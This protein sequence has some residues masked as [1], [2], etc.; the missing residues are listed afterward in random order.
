MESQ[1]S[2]LDSIMEVSVEFDRSAEKEQAGE[3][4]VPNL[5]FETANTGAAV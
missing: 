5:T 1:D 4:I 3:G 2:V